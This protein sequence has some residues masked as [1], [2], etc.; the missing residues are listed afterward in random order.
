MTSFLLP[1]SPRDTVPAP[2]RLLWPC[3]SLPYFRPI[4]PFGQGALQGPSPRLAFEAPLTPKLGVHQHLES[5]D[6]APSS[7]SDAFTAMTAFLLCGRPCGVHGRI[8][9]FYR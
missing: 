5:T 4:S 7:I 2:V 1:A 9:P 8:S 3:H 6:W